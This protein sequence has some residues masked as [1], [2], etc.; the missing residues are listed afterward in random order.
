MPRPIRH[1]DPETYYM[2]TNR[3]LLGMFL[4]T[5]DEE[6]RRIIKGCLARAADQH[7]VDLVCFC[8]LANHF[9]LI[10]R[11]PRCN[12]AEFMEQFQGQLASRLNKHR[13]RSGTVFPLRYDDQALLDDQVLED[14]IGYVLNNPLKDRQVRA[15]DRW[16]GVTSIDCHVDEENTFEGKW[17]N[18]ETKRKYQRRK[19]GDKGREDAMETHRVELHLPEWLDGETRQERRQSLLEV[20]KADRHRL[21]AEATGNPNRAPRVVG[22]EEIEQLD[23]SDRP[24]EHPGDSMTQTRWLGVASKGAKMADYRDKRREITERYREAV[25]AWR[26]REVR[27]F[28]VGTY[29]PGWR[30]CVGSPLRS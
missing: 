29:P 14:K 25:S 2:L 18:H 12:M 16:P 20:V 30:H 24:D 23:W 8:F 4:L 11:F 5:P 6:C 17:L 26:A 1:V 9:H 21:W 13:D 27:P 22:P 19:T 28:P 7:D 10:A 3:C 15:A